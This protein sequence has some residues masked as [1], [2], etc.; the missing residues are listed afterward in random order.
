M[1]L[2]RVCLTVLVVNLVLLGNFTPAF[3]SAP[4]PARYGIKITKVKMPDES[5][6]KLRVYGHATKPGVGVALIRKYSTG[7][8]LS[9]QYFGR[10]DVGETFL[11]KSVPFRCNRGA[12]EVKVQ[13]LDKSFTEVGTVTSLYVKRRC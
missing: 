2:K 3:A 1:M 7:W 6:S 11:L 8:F 10:L 12:K 13:A 4:I 9:G 5:H